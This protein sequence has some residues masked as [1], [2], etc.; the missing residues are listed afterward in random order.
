M[1]LGGSMTHSLEL[2]P[3]SIR[4]T[5]IL[6]TNIGITRGQMPKRLADKF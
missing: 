1:E 4:S 5:I 6:T 3:I 2:T